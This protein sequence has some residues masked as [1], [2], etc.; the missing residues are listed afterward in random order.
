MPE[1][2]AVE[3]AIPP[4]VVPAVID[5]GELQAPNFLKA[6]RVEI[7]VGA[8][9]LGGNVQKSQQGWFSLDRAGELSGPTEHCTS[10][11]G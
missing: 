6:L 9:D 8:P 4:A 5:L 11:S 10:R 1:A 2:A 7:F 3:V